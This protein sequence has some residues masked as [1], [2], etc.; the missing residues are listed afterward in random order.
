MVERSA[1]EREVMGSIGDRVLLKTIVKMVP[2]ASSF[3]DQ[4]IRIDMASFLSQILL[5][6]W[7][8]SIWNERSRLIYI[9]EN[10][11]LRNCCMCV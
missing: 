2:D 11:L 6:N 1:C 4:H 10:N 8:D 5:K 3:K 9:S 7:M